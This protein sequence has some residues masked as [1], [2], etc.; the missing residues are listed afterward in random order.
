MSIYG[1]GAQNALESSLLFSEKC[2]C[3]EIASG[4]TFRDSANCQIGGLECAWLVEPE[5]LRA[6]GIDGKEAA[7][8]KLWARGRCPE[9]ATDRYPSG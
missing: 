6:V 2:R 5:E 9:M 4:E 1:S 8:A 7:F 3:L